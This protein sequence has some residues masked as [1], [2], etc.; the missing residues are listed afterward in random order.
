MILQLISTIYIIIALNNISQ[1]Y[2]IDSR[3]FGWKD[4]IVFTTIALDLTRFKK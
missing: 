1:S 2:Y 3:S 4:Y